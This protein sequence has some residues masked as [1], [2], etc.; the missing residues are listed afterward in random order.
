MF[1]VSTVSTTENPL[2]EQRIG[3]FRPYPYLASLSSTHHAPVFPCNAFVN[4][5]V[6]L[7]GATR[8]LSSQS[9]GLKA[10]GNL[11]MHITRESSTAAKICRVTTAFDLGAR[12][13]AA[14]SVGWVRW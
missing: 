5:T 8:E 13:A 11:E 1:L 7:C 6:I 14:R 12:V 9:H 4:A 3:A 2:R 10:L